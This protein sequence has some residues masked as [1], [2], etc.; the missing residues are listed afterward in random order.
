MFIIG[1]ELN[2]KYIDF[3]YIY[4]YIK[5]CVFF[6][7]YI[8]FTHIEYLIGNTNYLLGFLQNHFLKST[9]QWFQI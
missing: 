7:T 5:C 4:I 6:Y 9:I 8:I 1:F 3:T 2:K